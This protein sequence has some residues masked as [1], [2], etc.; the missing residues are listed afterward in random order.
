MRD[1]Q[2]RMKEPIEMAGFSN[3]AIRELV[4]RLPGP[5]KV[6][7]ADDEP[8]EGEVR[9]PAEVKAS[10]RWDGPAPWA[11]MDTLSP[12]EFVK[13]GQTLALGEHRLHCGDAT[14]S[15]AVASLMR[16][17]KARMIFCD[18]PYGVGARPTMTYVQKRD[19]VNKIDGDKLSGDAL[20]KLYE[21]AL[22]LMP[23]TP[24]ASYYVCFHWKT[25]AEVY[26]GLENLRRDKV[27]FLQDVIVWNKT[28]TG[29]GDPRQRRFYSQYELIAFAV[30]K[31]KANA[32][33]GNPIESNVWNY[34][35][36]NDTADRGPSPTPL[37]SQ[38]T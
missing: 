27:C 26:A 29:L 38:S 11:V 33:Y 25:A 12:D 36:T 10:L 6:I 20:T 18:P 17:D 22:R 14:D 32:W 5:P 24:D 35:K 9:T 8:E 2:A 15:D 23:V 31:E 16:G 28:R 21:S 1:M 13:T 3:M 19:K 4:A 34:R 30:K 37:P 7:K